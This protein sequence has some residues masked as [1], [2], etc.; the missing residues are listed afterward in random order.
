MKKRNLLVSI[1]TAFLLV[2]S[3]ITPS[4]AAST[5]S[6]K[7]LKSVTA[8]QSLKVRNDAGTKYKQIGTAKK[9]KVLDVVSKKS[10]WYKIKWNGTFGYV[11]AKY[12]KAVAKKVKL[13]S[14]FILATTTSTQDSGL[15][16]AII[17]VFEAKY[18][19][20]VKV[21]AVGT[22]QAIKMGEQGDADV[23]LVHDRKSEDKFV[24]EKRGEMAYNL[25]Y[26]QF[27]L[28]G[29][30][31]DPAKIKNSKTVESALKKIVST[32]STFISRGDDSGT[33]KKEISIWNDLNIKPS[34]DWYKKAGSGMGDTLR[35]ADEMGGYT[36]TDEATFLTNKTGLVNLVSGQKELLN[37]YGI[38]RV[39]GT[40]KPNSSKAFIDFLV[41]KEGQKLI[42][43]YGKTKFG[44][45]LFVPNASK[46]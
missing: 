26:N 18:D 29:P 25:M 46:R 42:G 22:G 14:N 4:F 6:T 19:V 2:F 15:L 35:M 20:D 3:I 28:V 5:T 21:V 44:K 27:L 40:K 23:L 7:V 31:A 12:T 32:K 9:G 45:P 24:K 1:L 17:P 16:D 37:P 30:K 43:K 33:N 41:S 39:V 34:G 36:L 11:Y 10:T 38:M 13:E 8:S